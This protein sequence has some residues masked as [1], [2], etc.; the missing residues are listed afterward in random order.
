MIRHSYWIVVASKPFR[1]RAKLLLSR[2]L[3][4]FRLAR[5]LALPVLNCALILL[6]CGI[7]AAEDLRCLDDRSDPAPSE[8]VYAQLQQR[9]YAALDRRAKEFE[10]LETPEQIRAYQERLRE[11]FLQQLGGLP[12]RTPLDAKIVGKL[13]G[14]GYRVEKVIFASQPRHHVTAVLY[15]PNGPAP[16]PGVV[17]ASGHSRTAKSAGYNQRFG[18]ALAQNGIAALCYDPIGQGERSQIL[19]EN[20]KPRFTS[21]TREH[22]LIGVGSILVGTNTA[23][24]RIWDGMR[25]I[26]YLT[27]REDI[28]PKRIGFTGC[29]GGG[30]LT[31]YVMALDDRVACAAPACYLTTFRRLIET[32]GPQDAEQNIFGQ[33][34]FGMDQPDYVLMHAPRPTLISAT[35]GDFFDIRGTWENF[36]QAKR[37]YTRLGHAGRVDLVEA[38]GKHGVR[39]ENLVAIVRWMRRWLLDKDDAVELLDPKLHSGEKL[40]CTE[41]GQ[42]L[43]LPEERSVFDLNVDRERR[44]AAPRRKLWEQSTAKEALQAV[45][46]TAGVRPLDEIGKLAMNEVG[47]VER[48]GYHIDKFVLTTPAG[49]PLPGLAF[50]PADP[51]D[52]AYLY[53]HEDGKQAV[54]GAGGPVEKLVSQGYVV[55]AV[56]LRGLGETAPRNRDDLLGNWKAFYLAYLLGDS[57]V[58]L[59]TE[60]VLACGRWVSGYKTQNPRRVHLVGVGSAGIPALHAAALEP[61]LFASVVLRDTL[62]SWSNTVGDPIPRALLEH[63]VH[64][65]LRVYDLPDLVRSIPED[66]ITL[67]SD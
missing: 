51:Q 29:S 6:W 55:V 64:G 42:V 43:L 26:D 44:L 50:H 45:R 8:V 16:Y 22:F 46:K 31:S 62:P 39:P 40:Q 20:G 34:G 47:R 10:K 14:D 28:D 41:K 35:T 18:I 65:A 19:D 57:L 7:A 15:L 60:D 5:S 3:Q 9:A 58:G 37:I 25:A 32:I 27:S 1:G 54:G 48:D 56:D 4:A 59:R 33:I 49:M 38:D 24:Y 12:E 11:F 63:T 61:D 36:R 53:L 67:E 66:R 17:V 2:L 30:T 13:S 52:D 23:R 21:T